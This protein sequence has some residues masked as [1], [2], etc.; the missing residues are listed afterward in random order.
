MSI[1]IQVSIVNSADNMLDEL[2]IREV[3]T[4]EQV[5]NMPPSLDHIQTSCA[6]LGG[7]EKVSSSKTFNTL[8]EINLHNQ[9]YLILFNALS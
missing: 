3:K 1:I 4:D 7:M 5:L 8:I 6:L 2:W 9:V